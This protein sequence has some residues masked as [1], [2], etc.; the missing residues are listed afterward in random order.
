LSLLIHDGELADA[1]ALMT[2]LGLEFT[3]RRGGATSEDEA[4][5]WDLVVSTPKRLLEFGV[6]SQDTPPTRVAI[7]DKDSRTLRSMLQ[8]AGI[9]LIVRRPVHPAALRLLLLHALYRGPPLGDP[10]R[11]LRER[12]PASLGATTPQ[13][14]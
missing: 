13:G 4:F 7:L 5:P 14:P 8:R 10:R 6:G 3:E 11:P 9:N 2:G 12:L 1:C